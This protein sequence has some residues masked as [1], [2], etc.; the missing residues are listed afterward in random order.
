MYLARDRERLRNHA[1]LQR[2]QRVDYMFWADQA[3]YFE[4]DV[5]KCFKKQ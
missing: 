5:L 4:E 2:E 1:F 3:P